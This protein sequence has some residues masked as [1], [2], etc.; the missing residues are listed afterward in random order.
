MAERSLTDLTV[1][2]LLERLASGEPTPGGGAAAALAGALGAALVSMVCNLTIGRER[3]AAFEDAATAIRA[4]AAT[5]LAALKA[6]VQRDADAY[7][8]LMDAFR[9]PRDTDDQKS[10]RSAE[11]QTKTL[12]AAT[13]PLEIAEA[14]ARVIALA[15]RAVGKTNPNAA[16]DLAVAALLGHA[17]VESAAE[18]VDINLKSLK[19]EQTHAE[20]ARRLAATRD[21][22]RERAA[23]TVERSHG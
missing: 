8:S 9:L 18:N 22:Q 15:E 5:A 7:D 11:I 23:R 4:E 13:V 14:S 16:S 6:G 10:A 21:G 3:Y 12:H 1:S 19:D 17:A 20:I 2:E